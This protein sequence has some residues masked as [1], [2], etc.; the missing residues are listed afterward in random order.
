MGIRTATPSDSQTIADFN[1]AMALE[2]E[3]LTLDSDR[4][5]AGVEA[6]LD[7]S[8]KGFYL[9]AERDGQVTGQMM[10][11]YEWSDWRNATFWWIQSV[12]VTPEHRRKGVYKALY[13]ALK[14]MA[15]DSVCGFRLY[16]E[17]DNEQAK[18]TYRNLGMDATHYQI[19]EQTK[20]T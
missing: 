17:Q 12:Y 15:P 11:T 5:L 16:V 2:T 14:Q 13:S 3:H 9:L 18:S 6:L 19:F 20:N 10:L 1:A 8:S 4:V 7:D